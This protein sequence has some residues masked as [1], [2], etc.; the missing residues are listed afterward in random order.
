MIRRAVSTAVKLDVFDALTTNRPYRTALP[1]EE[2]LRMMREEA[3]RGWWD[4][5]LVE[6][7]AL[8]LAGGRIPMAPSRRGNAS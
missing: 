7:F 5:R 3:A 8:L 2:A 4:S 1:A 6:Q